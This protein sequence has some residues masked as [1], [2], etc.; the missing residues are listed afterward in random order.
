MTDFTETDR[1]LLSALQSDGKIKMQDLATKLQMSL[2]PVWRRV[3]KYE[4]TG[5]IANYVAL[6]SQKLLGL[7]ALAY[8]HVSLIDHTEDSIRAFD[9]FV[10]RES[11]I[12]ECCSITGHDDYLLKV[13]ARDP[14]GLETFLMQRVLA[15]GIV[16]NSTTHFVLRQKKF[17]TA[18]PLDLG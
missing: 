10:A 2:S 7:N 16:R 11:Q 8:V 1:R 4:E 14:E 3:R 5:L 17:T 12:I 18:L 6:L 13:V 15:L 9:D